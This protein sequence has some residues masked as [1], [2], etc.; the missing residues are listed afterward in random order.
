ME[1]ARSCC[2][3]KPC[4]LL[5]SIFRSVIGLRVK[6]WHRNKTACSESD[7]VQS[8]R[9][10]ST[11][12]LRKGCLISTPGYVECDKIYRSKVC[13]QEVW[14]FVSGL[15]IQLEQSENDNPVRKKNRLQVAKHNASYTVFFGHL[16][17]TYGLVVKVSSRETDDLGSMPARCW[18]ILLPLCHFAWHWACQCTDPRAFINL[19]SGSL[20]FWGDFV[21]GDLALTEL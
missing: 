9:S 17:R 1:L 7:P 5:R 11:T 14:Y 2:R 16:I 18:N 3:P 6:I 12:C 8:S 10:K 4:P 19:C 13:V 15:D 21:S 20:Y